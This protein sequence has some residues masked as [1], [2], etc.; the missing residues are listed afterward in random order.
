MAE[1]ALTDNEVV[2]APELRVTKFSAVGAAVVAGAAVINPVFEAILGEEPEAGH[3]VTIFVAAI[4]AWALIA[5]ADMLARS[6]ATAHSQ[7]QIAP[8]QQA[9][10][11]TYTKHEDDPGHLVV[12]LRF[13]PTNPD[14]PEFLIVKAGKAPMWAPRSDLKFD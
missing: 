5:S 3:K 6:L 14:E 4:A 7:P 1:T 11:V 8:I 13:N 9:M 10:K 12:A 2:K